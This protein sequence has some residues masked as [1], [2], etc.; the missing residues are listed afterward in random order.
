MTA[1]VDGKW[2]VRDTL[3]G[4]IYP[5]P[6]KTI[7]E[8]VAELHGHSAVIP[9]WPTDDDREA[10]RAVVLPVIA[11]ARN[12]PHPVARVML[13]RDMNQVIDAVTDAVHAAGFRLQ[14]PITNSREADEAIAEVARGIASIRVVHVPG[15]VISW[16]NAFER[17]LIRACREH[18]ERKASDAS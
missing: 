3:T 10:I 12:Y 9:G 1:G 8:K 2:S 17:A 13:G 15:H 16:T 6:N 11:N 4:A 14:R 5:Q 18:D 7:A